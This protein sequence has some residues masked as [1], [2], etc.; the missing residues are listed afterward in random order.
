MVNTVV[1]TKCNCLFNLKEYSWYSLENELTAV[2]FHNT[3]FI[4]KALLI[5]F[6][7]ILIL[8]HN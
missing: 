2:F 1:D 5:T 6:Q 8:C 7:T 4:E 3:E